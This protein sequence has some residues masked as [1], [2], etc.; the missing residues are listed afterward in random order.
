MDAALEQWRDFAGCCLAAAERVRLARRVDII[1]DVL[2]E[3]G[4]PLQ[5]LGAIAAE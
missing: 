4:V 1:I 5:Q 3:D 2:N